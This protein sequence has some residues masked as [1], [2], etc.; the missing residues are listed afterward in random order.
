MCAPLSRRVRLLAQTEGRKGCG[1]E[2]RGTSNR[3]VRCRTHGPS[4][5][6]PRRGAA[7]SGELLKNPRRSTPGI[8]VCAGSADS[9][10]EEEEEDDGEEEEEKL[11]SHKATRGSGK[12]DRD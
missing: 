8:Q 4:A 6:H 12:Q 1:A 3:G 9:F 2:G 11:S 10:E 5:S 7:R